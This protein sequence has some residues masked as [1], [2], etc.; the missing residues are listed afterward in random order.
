MYVL[1]WQDYDEKGHGG[2][3][4]WKLAPTKEKCEEYAK[5]HNIE[6]Y[7]IALQLHQ[8]EKL[9][10]KLEM[11]RKRTEDISKICDDLNHWTDTKGRS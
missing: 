3:H 7:D 4:H 9:E 1:Y 10:Y 6:D 8:V 11:I 2:E 5:E